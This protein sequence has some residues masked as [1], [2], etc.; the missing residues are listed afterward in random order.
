M[1]EGGEAP[2]YFTGVCS[3]CGADARA[4]AVQDS[5][6]RGDFWEPGRAECDAGC[7]GADL[8]SDAE[9]EAIHETPARRTALISQMF[10]AEIEATRG[11]RAVINYVLGGAR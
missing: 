3:I 2:A 11:M 7:K 5:D 4:D 10:S 9:F 6:D 8:V 1:H